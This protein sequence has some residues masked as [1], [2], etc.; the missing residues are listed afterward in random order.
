M[1]ERGN[2]DTKRGL[3]LLQVAGILRVHDEDGRVRAFSYFAG[4]NHIK[5]H[6]R[7]GAKGG[8]GK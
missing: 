8:K 2:V 1:S 3:R 7:H 6:K 4:V 5:L